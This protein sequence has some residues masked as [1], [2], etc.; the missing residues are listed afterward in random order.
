[1]IAQPW[2]RVK[3]PVALPEPVNTDTVRELG[4]LAPLLRSHLLPGDGAAERRRWETLWSVLARAEDL[5]EHA[6]NILDDFIDVT[7]DALTAGQLDEAAVKRARK[8]L[9][10]TEAAMERLF[11]REGEPLGWLGPGVRKYNSAGRRALD[12]LVRALVIHRAAVLE[13]GSVTEGDEDLWVRLQL[14]GLD[15]DAEAIDEDAIAG[16]RRT[17]PARDTGGQPMAWAGPSATAFNHVAQLVLNDVL[18]HAQVHR[19]QRLVAGLRDAD[20][21]LWMN[22]RRQGFAEAPTP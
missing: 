2:T 18:T 17:K 16:L 6:E 11:P 1:M 8:F 20:R 22:V 4:D 12:R 10:H 19:Q 14:N 21:A 9:L 13:E 5:R 15:P 3:Q 7:E